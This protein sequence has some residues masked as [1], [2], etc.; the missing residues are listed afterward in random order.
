MAQDAG[1]NFQSGLRDLRDV[2][3][4]RVAPGG[5]GAEVAGVD[6]DLELIEFLEA[7]LL[8]DGAQVAFKEQ[9]RSHLRELLRERGVLQRANSQAKLAAARRDGE[10]S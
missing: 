5:F 2:R 10:S 7:D 6:D 4:A 8:P 9:L 3:V 1:R